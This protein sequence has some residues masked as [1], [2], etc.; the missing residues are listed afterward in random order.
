ME[1]AERLSALAAKVRQQREAIQTEEAT[2]NAFVMP[3]IST[4]LGYDVFNPLEVVPEFTADVGI[5]KGEKIDYAIVKDGEIQILIECKKSIGPVR[6]E[7]AS[8]L[9]RYF[10]VTN[11]RI[12]ILTNGEVYQ[13]FTDLDAPNRMD[14]K[15]FLVLDL[16]DIDDSLLPELQKLSKDVFDLDSIINAAGELKYIGE[17]KRTLAAQFREP[18]D[19]WVKF[20]TTRVYTGPYT[21][22]VR[23]QFTSLVK[24]ASKQ[25]LNDQANE[26]L[27]KA[28]GSQTF[29]QID[30]S[31]ILPKV[32]SEPVV[33]SD[34]AEA[35][36]IATTLEEIEG[37]QIVRAIVCSDVKPSRVF[38]R[39]AKSYF[40]VLLDDNN[41]RPIARLHFNRTQK[42]IG[43][44]DEHKEERRV[45]IDSLEDIYEHADA[46]RASVKGYL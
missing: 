41:R 16:N 45:P 22:R 33:E 6:I 35:D 30:D 34:L 29:T 1:F 27:K 32:T 37:Y 3:F 44:F 4:I 28:L 46:L 40:A 21:Q 2:K 36:G 24:K 17:L 31:A 26:R 14:E 15:P 13:F 12:A 9:F 42:Y 39:D 11:A 10:A 7:H 5:K 25:F 8:Q 19:E 18:E 38:Q 43:L 20:L 23:E